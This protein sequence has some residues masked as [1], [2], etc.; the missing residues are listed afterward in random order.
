MQS[1]WQ[2]FILFKQSDFRNSET[3]LKNLISAISWT[4]TGVH[5]SEMT[6]TESNIHTHLG[7]VDHQHRRWLGWSIQSQWA[8]SSGTESHTGLAYRL[9]CGSQFPSETQAMPH[10]CTAQFKYFVCNTYRSITW[11]MGRLVTGGLLKDHKLYK[12]CVKCSK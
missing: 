7:Q 2:T 11:K 3:H 4:F 8:C 1:N 10:H 9:L 5:F 12:E 6:T